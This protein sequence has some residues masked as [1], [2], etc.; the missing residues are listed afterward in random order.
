M[1]HW[2]RMLTQLP[3]GWQRLIA[4]QHRIALPR[5]CDAAE[6]V[7]RLR[8]ALGHAA[9]VRVT[10]DLLD[11]PLQHA[12]QDLRTRRGACASITV[13][14]SMVPCGPSARSPPT[15]APSRSPNTS[16]CSAGCSIVPPPSAIRRTISS[17]PKSAAG[18]PVR[19]ISRGWAPHHRHRSPRRSRPPPWSCSPPPSSPWRCVPT[20]P[21]ASA[22]SAGCAN[23]SQPTW[24]P[25]HGNCSIWWC[26]CWSPWTVS[27]PTVG[28]PPSPPRANAGSPNRCGPGWRRCGMPGCFNPPAT[29]VSPHCCPIPTASTGRYC[30]SGCVTGPPPSHRT[31]G[32]RPRTSDSPRPGDHWP[33]RAPMAFGT[34]TV[35]PGNPSER[36]GSGHRAGRTAALAGLCHPARP[37]PADGGDQPRPDPGMSGCRQA[38]LAVWRRRTHP[39]PVTRGCDPPPA[40]AAVCPVAADECP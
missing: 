38:R 2:A 26:R 1:N 7:R 29:T 4:R 25:T 11:P 19:S 18:C 13:I 36:R 24:S 14:S 34:S 17:R 3:S 23:A 20:P 10:Y 5:G 32:W 16:V 15:V 39:P 37:V 35:P 33:I 27:A 30:A 21:C 40:V 28:S 31:S 6:R 12:L 8:H 9:T 22:V